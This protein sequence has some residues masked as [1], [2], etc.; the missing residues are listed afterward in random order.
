[1]DLPSIRARKDVA[2]DEARIP[3]GS[4]HALITAKGA[5]FSSEDFIAT[6]SKAALGLVR[7]ML[8]IREILPRS[9]EKLDDLP[10]W[11]R[12]L[13][14]TGPSNHPWLVCRW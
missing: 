8:F 1:M 9:N 4:T 14:T 3:P 6:A 11:T 13:W 7:L 2:C 10:A 12:L 5:E